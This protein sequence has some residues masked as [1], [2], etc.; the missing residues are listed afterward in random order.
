MAETSRDTGPLEDWQ[1]SQGEYEA[2]TAIEHRL[3]KAKD[4]SIDPDPAGR[5]LYLP[6]VQQRQPRVLLLDGGRGTGKTSLLVTLIERWK[7]GREAS[8]LLAD[9]A[10][11]DAAPGDRRE[12]K[13]RPSFVTPVA[14][15]DFD[16]LPPGM[17]VLAGL[18]QAWRPLVQRFDHLSSTE[19]ES[20]EASLLDEW[21]ALFQMAA[22][23]WTAVPQ[24]RGFVAQVLDREEQVQDWLNFSRQWALFIN[25]VLTE[26]KKLKEPDRLR[27]DT[28][29]VII[30]DD[31][32]LQVSRIKELLPALRL[33]YHPRVFFIVAADKPHMLEMLRLDFLGQQNRL[34]GYRAAP[35]E[36]TEYYKDAKRWADS[37]AY[38]TFEKVFTRENRW[39]LGRLSLL[40]FLAFPGRAPDPGALD[41]KMGF[42]WRPDSFYLQ[43]NKIKRSGNPDAK[44]GAG[45]ALLEFAQVTERFGLPGVMTFRRAQQLLQFAAEY[46]MF[47]PADILAGLISSGYK[48]LAR[49]RRDARHAVEVLLTG[50]LMSLFQPSLVEFAGYEI[51]MGTRPDFALVDPATGRPLRMSSDEHRRVNFT[52]LLSAKLLEDG[53]YPVSA[54]GLRWENHLSLAWTEWRE[55]RASFRWT[56]HKHPQPDQLFSQTIEWNDFVSQPRVEAFKPDRY[57]FA[58]IYFERKWNGVPAHPQLNPMTRGFAS[59]KLNWKLLLTFSEKMGVAERRKWLN[60]TLPL[61]ARPEIGFSPEVQDH[62]LAGLKE[63]DDQTAVA[64]LRDQRRRHLTD[65]LVEAA[66]QRGEDI[67]SQPDAE[68]VE[69]AINQIDR[70]YASANEGKNRW[71]EN[72]EP[73]TGPTGS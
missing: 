18:V 1:L 21:H 60:V 67:L 65:A 34:A 71:S 4:S 5:E 28:V 50:E 8:A 45:N 7:T 6:R 19:A 39:R 40:E 58:W 12:L 70:A 37:L 13:N 44:A 20:D 41:R 32:D 57:A 38:S 27:K 63:S 51:V 16:P 47:A 69:R 68:G 9:A 23:G 25:K 55:P 52:A 64:D 15:I 54:A 46:P 24:E 2:I 10:K 11:A 62:L 53:G 59:R 43:L 33:L 48:D 35:A 36:A 29:F 30:I 56:R 66:A 42:E 31:C 49:A 14:N 61:L 3:F 26:G 17:P 22:A 73:S 72:I